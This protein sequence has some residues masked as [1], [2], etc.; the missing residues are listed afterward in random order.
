MPISNKYYD[1]TRALVKVSGADSQKFLQDFFTDLKW[2]TE[3]FSF[4]KL[5]Y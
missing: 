5:H 3:N 2:A 4:P 1:K